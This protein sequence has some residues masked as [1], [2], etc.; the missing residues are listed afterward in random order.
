MVKI[1][2]VLGCSS[3]AVRQISN[4]GTERKGKLNGRPIYWNNIA[5]TSNAMTHGID[6]GFVTT[7]SGLLFSP[8]RNQCSI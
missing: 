5:I 1:F 3:Y 7:G 2:D 4:R 8:I 6:G